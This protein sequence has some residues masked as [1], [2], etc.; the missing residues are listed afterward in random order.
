LDDLGRLDGTKGLDRAFVAGLAIGC[1]VLFAVGAV[2][3]PPLA[4]HGDFAEQWSAARLILEGGQPYDASTWREGAARLAGRASDSPVFIYP[5]YAAL[6][7]VPLAAIPIG[8]AATL[9][10]VAGMLLAALGIRSLLHAYPPPHV[11]LGALFGFLLL[12][13]G[14]ALLTL[15]QGQW[16]FALVAS[17]SASCVAVAHRRPATAGGAAL[18]FLFKPQLAP[19]V[20]LAFARALDGAARWRFVAVMGV[21]ALVILSTI[22]AFPR[23]WVDWYQGVAGFVAAHPVR[24]TTL[25]T[26]AEA[27]IGPFGVVVAAIVTLI[28]V[29]TSLAFGRRSDAHLP[30]WLAT[31]VL[32]APYIQA[33][34]HIVLLVPLAAAVGVTARRSRTTSFAVATIGPALLVVGATASSALTIARGQDTVGAL[35]PAA[36]WLLVVIALWP[37]RS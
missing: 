11:L 2:A 4:S 24:T 17:A 13:S 25:A 31:A 32:V 36:I 34:D 26:T 3:I 21:A 19:F 22:V 7:F 37:D 35:V 14:P 27:L 30:V 5:P 9:W 18:A 8:A 28:A 12:A 33:Y 16:G 23:W 15:A 6:A 29:G 1:V 20:V 10:L